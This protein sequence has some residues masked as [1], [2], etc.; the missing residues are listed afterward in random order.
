MNMMQV[1]RI[2]NTPYVDYLWKLWY[3]KVVEKQK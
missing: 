2:K 3:N 1:I